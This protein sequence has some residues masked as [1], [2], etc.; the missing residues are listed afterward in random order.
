MQKPFTDWGLTSLQERRSI[1]LSDLYPEFET[2]ISLRD[3]EDLYDKFNRE[4]FGDELPKDCTFYFSPLATKTYGKA[5]LDFADTKSKAKYKIMLASAIQTD[6]ALIVDVLLHEMIHIWQ[7]IYYVSTGKSSYLD[8]SIFDKT[9]HGVYFKRHMDRLNRIGFDINV[10]ADYESEIDLTSPAY[11]LA[12]STENADDHVILWSF[13]DFKRSIPELVAE[14]QD[15]AGYNYNVVNYFNTTDS[16]VLAGV[17]VTAK[18][19]IPKRRVNIRF[20]SEIV[21]LL[22]NSSLTTLTI[23]NETLKPAMEEPANGVSLAE[24]PTEVVQIANACHKYRGK[25]TYESYL[26]TVLMNTKEYGSM[27]KYGMSIFK[28]K[29]ETDVPKAVQEYIFNDWLQITDS[30]IKRSDFFKYL[31]TDLEYGILTKKPMRPASIESSYQRYF[32]DEET[33]AVA[34]DIERLKKLAPAVFL[35]ALK[36]KNKKKRSPLTDTDIM[37]LIDTVYFGMLLKGTILER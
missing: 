22:L 26:K 13:K 18:N 33:G 30:E 7:Y 28:Q 34:V 2:P 14:A 27:A 6:R 9:G 21:K 10:T 32:V 20:P 3:L 31:N 19:K 15:L 5:R 4:Y 11:C 16:T 1:E 35:Q 24:I 36:K 29:L 37:D 17:R 23:D 12:I 8:R 25:C